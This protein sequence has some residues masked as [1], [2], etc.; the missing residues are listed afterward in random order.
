M[1]VKNLKTALNW[2]Y[3]EIF[4]IQIKI[5]I[6]TQSNDNNNPWNSYLKKYKTA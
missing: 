6:F 5:A 3:S 1:L 2:T 4:F